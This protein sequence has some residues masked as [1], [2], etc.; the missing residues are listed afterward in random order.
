MPTTLS[1]TVPSK[2]TAD[3]TR[4]REPTPAPQSRRAAAGIAVV[5]VAQLM[6][7]LDLTV[8]NVAL[9]H[10][11][12]A[13]DFGTAGLSWVLNGY[14]LAFGGLLLLGGRLGDVFG[15][16]RTFE[17]G[18]AVFTLGSLAG[19]LAQS[20]AWLVAAR[21]A[22]GV[23]AALASPGVLAL[24]TTSAPT[25]AAR[26]RAL[27][28]FGAVTSGGMSLGLLLGGAVT[29]AGSWRWT[30]FINVPIGAAVL[31]VTRRVLHETPRRSGRFDLVGALSAT[32]GAVSVVW[33][34]IGVP[35]HGWTS[36]RTLGALAVGVALLLALGVTETHVAHPLVQ[37]ALLRSPA[38]ISSLVLIALVLGAQMSVFF[39]V[40]QYLEGPLGLGPFATGL[41]FMPLTL[42][43]FG[44]SR[45]SPR[46]LERLGRTPM[47]VIGTI[48]LAVSF[49][50]LSQVSA[51][52][53]YLSGMFGPFLLNG[54]SAG[55]VFLPAA[56]AVLTGVA[57][58]HA[59]AA[60]GL[61][62]TFQQ[63]GGA[64]GLAVI[65]SVYA[66][67]A[68]PGEFLPGVE[69]ALQ[70]AAL[71]ALGG[72]GVTLLA[73]VRLRRPAVVDPRSA[74]PIAAELEDAAA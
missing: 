40:A 26:N 54:L 42:A 65:V 63:L 44:M 33:A 74:E 21:G 64:I 1:T 47:V 31:A 28:L 27:A 45:V 9:P 59:G 73:A 16:R 14:T 72:L 25:Q 10:I 43:I 22:Q 61:L 41:A 49:L 35:E 62:Q 60:S 56:S 36:G 29:D 23:G 71:F 46:L 68:V 58:E 38:R 15:R 24:L 55:F 66:A 51:S 2:G 6:L 32:A 7:I 70:T 17:I 19:G 39:L 4:P 12:D 18:I 48:G 3:V 69:R 57:P 11:D 37:P 67:G 13:L 52:D 53:S 20:A 8:V 5:L 34:L 50:W 30:L